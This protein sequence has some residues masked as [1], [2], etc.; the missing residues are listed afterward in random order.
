MRAAIFALFVVIVDATDAELPHFVG[1]AIGLSTSSD[2]ST[3]TGHHFDEVPGRLSAFIPGSAHFVEDRRDI[4]HLVCRGHAQV[5]TVD[6]DRRFPY[7][8]KSAN[9]RKVH[10]F[11]LFFRHEEI[12]CPERGLHDAARCTEDDAGAGIWPQ[13]AVRFRI[14]QIEEIDARLLDHA[15]ELSRRKRDIDILVS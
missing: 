15:R 10:V 11:E 4:A 8:R 14:R 9:G 12:G 5:D 7:A 6:V 1:R 13:G 3:S 2:A